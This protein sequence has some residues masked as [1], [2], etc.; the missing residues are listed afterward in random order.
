MLGHAEEALALEDKEVYERVRLVVSSGEDAPIALHGEMFDAVLCHGVIMY[1]PDPEALVVSLGQLA[2]PGGL[3]SVVAKNAASMA[4]SPALQGDWAAALEGFDQRHQTNGLGVDT[5]A[6]TLDEVEQMLRVARGGAGRLV[7]GAPVHRWLGAR[8][9]GAR[10]RGSGHG[11][12]ARGQPPR[13]L[14]PDEQAPPRR[15]CAG[16]AK[17]CRRI[18]L[19]PGTCDGSDRT[20]DACCDDRRD[21][22][23]AQPYQPDGRSCE[24][25]DLPDVGQGLPERYR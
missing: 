23:F 24:Y 20:Y 3:V 15:R 8:D 9:A 2:R 16:L 25:P 19:R 6:H 7:R 17:A 14:P 22:R 21:D 5:V 1:V 18:R 10:R 13:P 4:T 12:R 11:R